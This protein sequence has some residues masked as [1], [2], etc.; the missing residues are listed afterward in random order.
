MTKIGLY[1]NIEAL[2]YRKRTDMQTGK[3]L[4]IDEHETVS[5]YIK[6]ALME[7]GYTVAA[8]S[9]AHQAFDFFAGNAF[10]L[11]ITKFGMS[12]ITGGNL[13]KELKRIDK[14]CVVVVILDSA[15]PE[16][17]AE[18]LKLPA[19]YD[20]LTKPLNLE[21]LLFVVKKGIELHASLLKSQKINAYLEEQ[22]TALKKQNV[23][24]AR[25]IEESTS[26]LSKLY[27]D[28]RQTYLRTIKSLAHAIDT[29]DHYTHSHSENVAKYA[30]AIAEKMH[31]S[32]QEIE[33]IHEA[34]ELHDLG[35]IG[36]QDYILEKPGALT[37]EEWG[38]VR[39]HAQTGAQILEPLTFLGEVIE[40]V[41][42]HHERWD[43]KGYPA[44]LK[45]EEILLGARII[46]LADAYEAMVSPR[47]YRQVPL[48]KYE[49]IEEIKKNS[50]TQFDP[51]VVEVFLKIVNTL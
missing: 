24:L 28:L 33:K 34:C 3:I 11:V 8:M 13:V 18:I 37:T 43:G 47:S 32:A 41:R 44:G 42:Q 29:R 20:Y 40:L 35:K 36:I 46:N 45:Q 22:N 7:N 50:G 1:S 4:L 23:L 31:L 6:N 38:Q 12:G 27:D 49:A 25:R 51:K 2:K 21:R 15:S 10:D 17:V 14:N 48:T 26:N 16:A 5:E 30:V 39:K 19:V 9:A